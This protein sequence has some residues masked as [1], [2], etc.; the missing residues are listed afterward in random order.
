MVGSCVAIL[1]ACSSVG[2]QTVERDQ[3]D[4]GNT[5][6]NAL[7]QQL[8]A[9]IVRLRYMEAPVFVDVS[10]V[11]NQYA[12]VANFNANA[13]LNTAFGGDANTARVGGG[14]RWEDRPTI[15]YT[16]ISGKKFATS[17]LTPI[18]PESLFALV[19]SGWP[20]ELMFRLTVSSM[21]GVADSRP[22]KQA[23]PEFRKLLAVWKTLRDRRVIALRRSAVE[24]GPARILLYVNEKELDAEEMDEL[25]MLLSTLGL[26]ADG[27]E[28]TLSYGLIPRDENDIAVLTGSILDILVSLAWQIQAPQEHIDDGRTRPTFVDDGE[29]GAIFNVYS[30][31]DEPED[32]FVKYFNRGY[33]F[34]IDDRDVVTKRTFGVLQIML[35]LTDT[36]DESVG[37]VLT[38]GG[39]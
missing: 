36:G 28:F 9:N 7:Q 35:S 13:G 16:P 27:R 21:N 37:P 4:Y 22:P 33:W 11:I 14:G 12:V 18:P 31:K 6:N 24:G 20:P 19:Q 29:G 5:L 10:S 32:A 39:G 34:W 26:P 2:P 25:E 3:L 23:D 30:G 8:L 15:T 1:A 17:L 38:I